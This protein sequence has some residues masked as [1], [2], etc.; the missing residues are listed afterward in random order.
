M[1]Y[2]GSSPIS[3]KLLRRK[4]CQ[5]YELFWLRSPIAIGDNKNQQPVDRF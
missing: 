3:G 2:C 4:N 1:R 5:T